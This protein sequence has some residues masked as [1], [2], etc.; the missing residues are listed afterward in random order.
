MKSKIFLL[1]TAGL[2]IDLNKRKTLKILRRKNVPSSTLK[3]GNDLYIA[4]SN[5]PQG[6][7]ESYPAS[8]ARTGLNPKGD[9]RLE[10]VFQIT[11][12]L[13]AQ[14]ALML[15]SNTKNPDSYILAIMRGATAVAG[16]S[17]DGH[18]NGPANMLNGYDVRWLS[19]NIIPDNVET[20]VFFPESFESECASINYTYNGDAV[21]EV[22]DIT[23]SGCKVKATSNT[24]SSLDIDMTIIGR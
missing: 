16:I 24:L 5:D 12:E 3:S 15:T 4:L 7:P 10:G 20:E 19:I 18:Y 6:P 21:V 17:A 22:Y 8:W 2:R 9:P 13:D 14:A 23:P 1:E 11:Q